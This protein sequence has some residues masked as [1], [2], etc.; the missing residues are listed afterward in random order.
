LFVNRGGFSFLLRPT[1]L[2]SY[3]IGE[4]GAVLMENPSQ[5]VEKPVKRK[6]RWYQFSLRSLLI[7]V[8]LFAFACSWFA[9]KIGQAK[10]QEAAIESFR[11]R[12]IAI[13]YG[14]LRD[15]SGDR[16]VNADAIVPLWLRKILGD[17][18]FM[19]VTY[20][21]ICGDS[22]MTDADLE[23]LTEFSH[24]KWL[25]VSNKSKITSV[26]LKRLQ[27]VFPDLQIRFYALPD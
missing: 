3:N 12:A 2:G 20:A 26:G 15:S 21:C 6:L 14:Y 22:D 23:Q 9:V 25:T 11:K 17:D 7:F 27:K 5:S 19:N 24:L 16:A 1:A 8:T 4:Q 18:F 10:R 13:E